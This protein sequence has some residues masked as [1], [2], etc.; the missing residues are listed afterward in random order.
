MN[1]LIL[2]VSFVSLFGAVSRAESLNGLPRK[3]SNCDV[4]AKNHGNAKS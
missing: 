3:Y 2:F 1:N 4:M